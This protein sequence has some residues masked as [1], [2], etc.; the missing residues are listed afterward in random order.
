MNSSSDN[1][2]R[3]R[4]AFN[5]SRMPVNFPVP[6]LPMNRSDEIISIGSK[7]MSAFALSGNELSC[8]SI[9]ALRRK[10]PSVLS[11]IASSERAAYGLPKYTSLTDR[12]NG[13]R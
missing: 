2:V 3:E 9:S 12:V 7:F 6:F 4:L 10:I 5:G 8:E 1:A 11:V 13:L